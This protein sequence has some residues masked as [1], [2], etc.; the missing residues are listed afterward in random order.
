M[1]GNSPR[2]RIV[3]AKPG[4]ALQFVNLM[5]KDQVDSEMRIDTAVLE[6]CFESDKVM[7]L[8]KQSLED[9]APGRPRAQDIRRVRCPELEPEGLKLNQYK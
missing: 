3:E 8:F 4:W 9:A 7:R 5:T 6:L 2:S 1:D